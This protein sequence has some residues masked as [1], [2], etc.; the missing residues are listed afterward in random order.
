MGGSNAFETIEKNIAEMVDIRTTDMAAEYKKKN[1]RNENGVVKK[2]ENFDKIV[3]EDL[4]QN[5]KD[6]LMTELNQT[7]SSAVPQAVRDLPY[8]VTCAYQN[9]WRTTGRMS[10]SH[11]TTDWNNGDHANGGQGVLDTS[12]GTFTAG[13]AGH[14]TATISGY[15]LSTESYSEL[16][17]HLNGQQIEETKFVSG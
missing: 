1:E 2:R 3:N 5:L 11:L 12:T 4:R 16:Y 8:L 15:T 14:Y 17:M 10:Y 7:I 13:T 9:L 6:E